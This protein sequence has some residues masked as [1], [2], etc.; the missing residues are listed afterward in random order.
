MR[1]IS[2]L[3]L[4]LCGT[5]ELLKEVFTHY[6]HKLFMRDVTDELK[7]FLEA[8]VVFLWGDGVVRHSSEGDYWALKAATSASSV[9]IRPIASCNAAVRRGTSL[10]W[11]MPW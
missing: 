5:P 10:D 3:S 2:V 8:S 6:R 1:G 11:S 7:T 4:A 9:S